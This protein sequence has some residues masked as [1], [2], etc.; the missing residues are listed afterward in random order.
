MNS[1]RPSTA[2]SGDSSEVAVAAHPASL[3]CGGTLPQ[4]VD[5]F[6]AD[7]IRRAWAVFNVRFSKETWRVFDGLADVRL[8][9]CGACG[10]R[11]CEPHLAGSGGFYAELEQ[12][13]AT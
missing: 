7:E 9:E 3:L 11:F 5:V 2:G 13:K 6:P 12:Q 8:H 4:V 10:F 1:S